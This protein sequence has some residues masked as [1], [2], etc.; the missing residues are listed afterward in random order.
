M[1]RDMELIRSIL[2]EVEAKADANST[3]PMQMHIPGRDRGEISYHVGLLKEAGLLKAVNHSGDDQNDWMAQGL[4]WPGHEFLDT[5]RD[6][7]VWGKTK[8][9]LG[10]KVAS[11]SL[12]MLQEVAAAIARGLLGLA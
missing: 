8:E 11:V 2:L 1:K 10:S 3:F 7:T 5:I 6:E 9:Q 4:T 12:A